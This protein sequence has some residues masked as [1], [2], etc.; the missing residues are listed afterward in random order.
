[1]KY[2]IGILSILVFVA[3]ISMLV[4]SK[5]VIHEIEAFVL[6]CYSGILFAAASIIDI[7]EQLI[8]RINKVQ[9]LEGDK[10]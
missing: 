6:L 9:N 5:S 7:A 3:A 4:I 8:K 10:R 2:L 1:M